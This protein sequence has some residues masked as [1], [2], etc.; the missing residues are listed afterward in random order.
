MNN[1]ELGFSA[2]LAA[3]VAL[4][5]VAKLA[6]DS[7]NWIFSKLTFRKIEV[8]AHPVKPYQVR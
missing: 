8:E 4:P 5:A 1:T 7:M 3:F 2:L 6:A